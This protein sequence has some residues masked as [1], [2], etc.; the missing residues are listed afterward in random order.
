MYSEGSAI[1]SM[2]CVVPAFQISSD[3]SSEDM[4]TSAVAEQCL[5]IITSVT[6]KVS[7]TLSEAPPTSTH[8]HAHTHTHM[9]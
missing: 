3:L 9:H 5:Y 7:H 2:V 8:S 6:C 4:L 1:I